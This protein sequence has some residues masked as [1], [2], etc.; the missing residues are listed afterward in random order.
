M[1]LLSIVNFWNKNMDWLIDWIVEK[2]KNSYWIR[3]QISY[4]N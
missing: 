4:Y 3:L 1:H 2:F